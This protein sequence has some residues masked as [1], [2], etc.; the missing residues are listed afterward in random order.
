MSD[1]VSTSTNRVALG[2]DPA[3]RAP[4]P[5]S[6]TII[7]LRFLTRPRSKKRRDARPSM[8]HCSPSCRRRR[9]RTSFTV[10]SSPRAP[11]KRRHRR[12]RS[13]AAAALSKGP[14]AR[15]RFRLT[16]SRDRFGK[17]S[18]Q[19]R[20]VPRPRTPHRAIAVSKFP[21]LAE[22]FALKKNF[23]RAEAALIGWVGP[24]R[25]RLR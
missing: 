9:T 5:Y 15:S 20:A 19:S 1:F 14:A 18:P 13:G 16:L 23:D 7:S 12:F 25:E 2:V 4:S 17:D 6:S 11:L 21:H 22:M 24:Q 8:R 3:L 10:S